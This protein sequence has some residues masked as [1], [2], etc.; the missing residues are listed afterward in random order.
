M[1]TKSLKKVLISVLVAFALLC[2]AVGFMP[3]TKTT[4][5]DTNYTPVKAPTVLDKV[6]TYKYYYD[7]T[8]NMSDFAGV[9]VKT[10]VLAGDNTYK[11][12]NDEIWSITTGA[13]SNGGEPRNPNIYM[14]AEIPEHIRMASKN[15]YA[16]LTANLQ[17]K[18]AEGIS[19]TIAWKK[20]PADK[21]Y[22]KLMLGSPASAGTFDQ[23]FTATIT[24]NYV[25]NGFTDLDYK[26]VSINLYNLNG[27]YVMLHTYADHVYPGGWAITATSLYVKQPSF[28]L[29]SSDATAPTVTFDV[30]QNWSN[31]NK[32]LNVS[33]SDT[34]AGIK[35]ITYNGKNITDNCGLSSDTKAGSY[36]ITLTENGT[37]TFV[38]T[39]N[40][41]NSKTYTHTES[42]IDKEVPVPNVSINRYYYDYT[43]DFT[44][45]VSYTG[46]P[47]TF[48]YTVDG[49]DPDRNSKV[50]GATN[51]ETFTEY[52]DY[53]LKVKGYDDAGNESPVVSYDFRADGNIYTITTKANHATV[54]GGM[55]GHYGDEYTLDFTV[56]EG[57]LFHKVLYNG[58][59]VGVTA[60]GQTVIIKGNGELE[61]V[62][63]KIVTLSNETVYVFN[64]NG[65]V[66]N[67]IVSELG[68]STSDFILTYT[69]NGESAVIHNQG[70]YVANYILDLVD[71]VG[72][73]SFEVVVLPKEITVSNIETEYVYEGDFG[74]EYSISERNENISV[75]F[76]QNGVAVTPYKTGEYSY[77]F[78]SASDNYVINASGNFVIKKKALT[79]TVNG[80]SVFDGLEHTPEVSV[81][82]LIG[83]DTVESVFVM[84]FGGETVD[85][86]F[87]A[88]E[89]A[90]T[91]T[92]QENDFY[93]GELSGVITVSKKAITI[94]ANNLNSV[95]GE[96][97]KALTYTV[98]ESVETMPT[99]VITKEDGLNAGE[100]AIIITEQESN[101]FVFTYVN[102]VYTIAKKD[103]FV[104]ATEGQFKYYGEQDENLTYTV[105]GLI[106][107]D[108]LTGELDR[109]AGE[110]VGYYAINKGSLD[111]AN[112][113]I[114]FADSVFKILQ[115]QVV[116]KANLVQKT[117]G[118]TDPELI[119]KVLYG[120]L[121]DG[122]Y[123]VTQR[124]QGEDAGRYLI[125]TYA[126]KNQAGEDVS[127]NYVLIGVPSYLT[128]KKASLTVTAN[129]VSTEYGTDVALTY[130]LSSEV[131]LEGGLTRE[132]G[133][134]VGS[135]TIKL[136]TLNNPN[137]EITFISAEY[138]I[139]PKTAHVVVNGASKVYG[140]TETLTY[141]V[142]GLLDGDQLVGN[143][144]RE[145]GEDVGTYAITQG[146]LTHANYVIEFT[147]ANLVITAKELTVSV[148][149]A[150]KIYGEIDP[151]FTC[152]VEGV[153]A[154]DEVNVTL[155]REEG[156]DAGEYDI[157]VVGIDNDNYSVIVD[158]G[159]LTIGKATVD[160]EVNGK[161]VTYNGE[162]HAIDP[163]DFAFDVTVK[164]YQYGVEVEPIDAGVYDVVVTFDGGNNYHSVEKETTLTIEKKRVNI[165]VDCTAD[166]YTGSAVLPKYTLSE[167]MASVIIEFEG[168]L[169][170]IEKGEYKYTITADDGNRYVH[171]EGTLVIK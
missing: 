147:G 19:S 75:V 13:N 53:V 146:S 124:A 131:E 39:D 151:E 37:H 24:E 4:Y 122:D 162:L 108:T 27:P 62:C 129:A 33:F 69:K 96:E 58:E 100:Y 9:Y 66:P 67:Y 126:I 20:D 54:G 127:E 84:T 22:A 3:K 134:G 119:V 50:L 92:V 46:A 109:D 12:D 8:G 116:V 85:K 107:E 80:I 36:K 153:F 61:V 2:M 114:I 42:K 49:T 18:T 63:R 32:T 6:G 72:S 169:S 78:V 110:T 41:G 23:N 123:V 83:T 135:Y 65:F 165:F 140:E 120:T 166:K 51:S 171:Y 1:N 82:G 64:E 10:S 157:T 168:G 45:N 68:V 102:G 163:V 26:S 141:S 29:S 79:L 52:G 164:Y 30:N 111:N 7:S 14:Y 16:T 95:Y 89:Y 132:K 149:D 5:A 91:L 70:T 87:N 156:E 104:V 115:K 71:Y 159:T 145:V 103:A 59:D 155:G 94:T 56:E 148:N 170:P 154:G 93:T 40:V 35:T 97:I 60:S 25:N 142:T 38:V 34:Q 11:Y 101:N 106:G 28:T 74:F 43:V 150:E 152:S 112:Y 81:N 76:T 31:Q 160:F 77:E 138:V 158:N 161:T 57:Y 48:Y 44:A 143:I 15:G 139:T 105:S 90:Y 98:S 136:G 130:T 88:G 117:Y 121:K 99:F 133:N 118:E 73:G 21:M 144:V 167:E 17:M 47:T 113:N 86:I 55:S 128:I 137:Y 125:D